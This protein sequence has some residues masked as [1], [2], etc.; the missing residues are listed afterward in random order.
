MQSLSLTA[1]DVLAGLTQQGQT[2]SAD[3]GF[4]VDYRNGALDCRNDFHLNYATGVRCSTP[5]PVNCHRLT[6][7]ANSFDWLVIDQDN[8]SRATFKSVAS[9]TVDGS[10]ITNVFTVE[11]V[12]GPGVYLVIGVSGVVDQ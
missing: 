9:V 8:D 11:P 1:S 7:T 12:R 2:D 6:V 10:T 4:T 5:N 3:Y